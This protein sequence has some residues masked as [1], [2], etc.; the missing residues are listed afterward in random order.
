MT[1][2]RTRGMEAGVESSSVGLSPGLPGPVLCA[3]PASGV[4]RTW[5]ELFGKG[6]RRRGSQ[7]ACCRGGGRASSWCRDAVATR[8][9]AVLTG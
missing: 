4:T 6:C 8:S 3:E 2:G 1:S 5:W 9:P 7:W